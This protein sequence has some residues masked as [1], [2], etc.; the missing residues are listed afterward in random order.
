[1]CSISICHIMHLS[2]DVCVTVVTGLG[3]VDDEVD[4]E[5]GV[6]TKSSPILVNISISISVIPWIGLT[7]SAGEN[8][9]PGGK[10]CFVAS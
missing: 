1:M 6:H 7:K 5:V 4:V 9:T 2:P 10:P 8:V 3:G